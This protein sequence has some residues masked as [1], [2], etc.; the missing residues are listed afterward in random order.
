MLRRDFLDPR[1][2]G[3]CKIDINCGDIFL[4]I[5]APFRSRNRNNIFAL[6][7]HP[8]ERE[9]RPRAFFLA[10]DLPESGDESK[11]ALKIF[12]L[13]PRRRAPV[14]IVR[15]IFRFFDLTGQKSAAERT[16]RHNRAAS[17]KFS[18]FHLRSASL[19]DVN[20]FSICEKLSLLRLII[21]FKI[22]ELSSSRL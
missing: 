10:C 6:C 2:I 1:E 7:Q 5:F 8:G 20:G 11:I 12:A 9:L 14:I 21:S 3:A 18:L 4:Q 16:L 22:R 19:P 13:K 15:Q 17:S